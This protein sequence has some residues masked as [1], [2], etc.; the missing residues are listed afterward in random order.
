MFRG[1]SSQ[2]LGFLAP[3]VRQNNMATE[4]VY[5]PHGGQE[6]DR[7]YK[8]EPG[9][10]VASRTQP[11]DL[12]YLLQLDII[13][14]FSQFPIMLPS[15][16]S[17]R[18]LMNSCIQPDDTTMNSFNPGD[19]ITSGNTVTDAIHWCVLC[20]CAVFHPIN[21]ITQICYHTKE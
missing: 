5:F 17:V 14:Y 21:R 12:T 9:Q 6:T 19:V 8:K 7:E 15:Y 16:E 18:R 3:M 20:Q 10:D 11:N 2:P 4:A 1:L 13:S